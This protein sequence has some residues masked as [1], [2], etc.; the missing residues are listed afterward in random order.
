MRFLAD[1]SC[2]FCVVRA[3]RT[4]GHDVVAVAEVAKGAK[5]PT[6]IKLALEEGRILLAEE[7]DFGRLVFAAGRGGRVSS[8]F[9]SPPGCVASRRRRPSKPRARPTGRTACAAC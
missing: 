1:E 8:F 2:D 9:A 4:V 5:D 7:K 6:V 3:L